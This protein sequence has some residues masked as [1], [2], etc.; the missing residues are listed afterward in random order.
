[1]KVIDLFSGCGGMSMGFQN[2]GYEVVAAF[3]NWK[4]AGDIYKLN[5][6]HPFHLKDLNSNESESIIDKY[7][8]DMIIGGPPCQDFSIAGKRNDNGK[9]ANLT[10]KFAELVTK[11][12]PKWF[13]MENV[14]NITKSKVLPK[15]IELF[16]KAGYGLTCEV[17]N[18]SYL[19]IPQARKRFFMIGKLDEKHDFL[20][21]D[22]LKNHSAKPM[23]VKE[24]FGNKLDIDFYYAHPR[25]Y[26]RRAVFSVHEPSSTIRGVNR[27]IPK[28]YS[29][30]SADKSEITEYVRPLTSKERSLIQTF[31]D[32][33]EFIGS[34]TAVEQSIGNAVPVKMAEHVASTIIN[35]VAND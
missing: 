32:D 8:F 12:R 34:K 9:R 7:S 17:L 6:N 19:G 26:K 1:M 31:P 28:G 2:A 11:K 27:P 5:F 22:L 10:L 15:I 14:Y 21:A 33:F 23:S 20:K 16:D 4:G 35:F 13:V 18:A 24:Y 25:S 30:H 3:D 29:K